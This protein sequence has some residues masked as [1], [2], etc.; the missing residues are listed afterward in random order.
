[1]VV[2]KRAEDV[3]R[4]LEL[5]NEFEV[6]VLP[7]GAATSQAGQTVGRA[8]VIDASKYLTDILSLDTERRRVS[9]EPGVVLDTLNAYLKPHGLFFPVDVSTSSRATIGGMAGNNSVGARSLRYGHMVDNV[10]GI[11][12]VLASGERLKF[13]ASSFASP[14]SERL[15]TLATR[16]DGLYQ[17]EKEEIRARYPQ[18]ARNVAGYNLDRLGRPDRNLT[19]LL[20]GS[21]GTLAWFERIDLKLAPLPKHRVLGIC[22]FPSFKAAM[23]SAQHLVA[24]NPTV[25]ELV[26]R[27]V[28][29]LARKNPEFTA[30]L[31]RFVRGEPAAVFLVELAGDTLAE[32][33]RQLDELESLMQDLGFHDAVVRAED[34]GSQQAFWNLRK[35]ALNIIMSAKGDGKPVSFVEDCAVPLD[36]LADYTERL[37]EIFSRHGTTGTWYAHA[38]VGCL[39]V[40]PILNLKLELDRAKLRVIAEQAHALVREYKGSH[41]GEHGDGIARSEFLETMLGPRIAQ[42][43]GEIKREFDPEGRL[44]PGKIVDPR[45]MD[46]RSL[47]R[48]GQGYSPQPLSESLDWSAWG[49]FYRA[50]EMCNNNG[51][52]RKLAAGVMCPSF[53]ATR[54]EKHVTRGRANSLRLALTGQLGAGALDSKAMYETMELCIGCKGCKRECP[55]G[56]DMYRM[57]IEFLSQYRK[58]HT[59]TVRDRLIAYLPRYAPWVSRLPWL[60]NAANH[61]PALASL[62]ER[63]LGFSAKRPMPAWRGDVYTSSNRERAGGREVVLLAD[64]FNTYFHPET[65]TA[66]AKVLEAAGFNVIT[67][68]AASESRPLCCG[69]TFLNVGL[70]DE[71]KAEARRTLETLAPYVERGVAV[72]GLE[73]SCLLTLRDEFLALLPGEAA[74][75]LARRAMLFEEFLL[76]ERQRSTLSLALKALPQDRA[77][78][79]GHCHQKAFGLG[80]TVAEVLEWIPGLDVQ[81]ID[82]GCCGMA[83]SFGYEAEHYAVSMRIG[84][85]DLLPKIRKV[86]AD[87]LIVA[88]GFSCRH[89]IRD[90]A[91]RTALHVASVLERAL[92]RAHPS[93]MA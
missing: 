77:I 31:A 28:M 45:R 14:S 61:I 2:P 40:R 18:V 37:S 68:R 27:T 22:H 19:D 25:V 83:G 32:P 21:E 33:L 52:C 58:S 15:Q 44:N 59:P 81:T 88:D 30:T 72:V 9:V 71:A 50:A 11:D 5:A 16:L 6:P 63:A 92:D 93:P 79:H 53:R 90:G 24:L 85:L 82:S 89:Q 46:D 17:R 87:A 41:S 10:C 12:A 49:G 23:E 76:S 60:A 78:V 38:A 66:A 62:Q 8:L 75:A 69:R 65:V 64:T 13:D 7:R 51:A 80:S 48:Y 86:G 1:V 70:V 36:K 20:V 57:K 42:A 26:D 54:D 91:Q 56:V 39:H 43:F 3:Y 34:P 84:E 67:P 55:T 29:D 74:D 4:A 73:P 35:A 47:L